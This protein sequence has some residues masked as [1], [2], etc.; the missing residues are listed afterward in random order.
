MNHVD[1]LEKEAWNPRAVQAVP[2]FKGNDAEQTGEG[3]NCL[4]VANTGGL[5]RKGVHRQEVSGQ[6]I[7]NRKESSSQYSKPF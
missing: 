3:G 6:R 5:N 2:T 1:L 4:K 7:D